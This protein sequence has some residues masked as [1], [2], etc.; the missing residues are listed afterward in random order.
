MSHSRR[1]SVVEVNRD[2]DGTV[3]NSDAA[4]HRLSQSHPNIGTEINEARLATQ[5]EHDTTVRDSIKLYKKAIIYSIIL[6]TA[7]V[8]EGYDMSLMGSFLGFPPFEERYV[9]IYERR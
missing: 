7:V 1:T 8:M 9:T 5:R 3:R 2:K 6:S 4:I